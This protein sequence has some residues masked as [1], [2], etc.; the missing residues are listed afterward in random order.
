MKPYLLF[1]LCFLTFRLVGQ[2]TPD[3]TN[4]E[5]F[6]ME[7]VSFNSAG[8][9]L[10]GAIYKP[11]H[12]QAA[13]V[14]VHGSGQETR[15]LTMAALLAKNGIAVLT[16]D[17]RGVGKS[18]GIYAGPEVGSNNIDPSN[19]DLLASDASAAAD[20]LLRHLTVK[21]VP[22]G[23]VGFSQAGWV[24]PL[25]TQ[26]NRKLKFMVLFS[27]PVATTLEQLRFQFYTQGNPRFWETHSEAQAREH[28]KNDPDKYQFVPT[29][30]RNALSTHPIPGLWIFG[31]K[32]VQAPVGLSIE[33]LSVLKAE[34]KHYEYK[35]FPELG[36]NTAFSKS[37]E[38][39]DFVIQWI[40]T[41]AGSAGRE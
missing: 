6:T 2:T 13:V 31:G 19:L 10:E 1:F 12:I 35:F 37:P 8:I 28:I 32:D 25:A 7:N 20:I 14:I 40:K 34:G 41:I 36:H 21:Q 17:K 26:K 3:S 30:P 33:R 27:G 16:Y 23:L 9:T 4:G 5:Q 24:I 11:R 18:G 29:D 15:M 39:V 22:L 38:P